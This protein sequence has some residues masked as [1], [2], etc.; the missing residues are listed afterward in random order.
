MLTRPPNRSAT[1]ALI[2][3]TCAHTAPANRF[4]PSDYYPSYNKPTSVERFLADSQGARRSAALFGAFEYLVVMDADMILRRPLP[5]P[6]AL[7]VRRGHIVGGEYAY[8]NGADNGLADR[9]L[10]PPHAPIS[11]VGG[12]I[13]AHVADLERITPLWRKYTLDV[14]TAGEEVWEE[15]LANID[16]S[17]CHV[18]F[19]TTF[20]S[21]KPEKGI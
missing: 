19:R 9:F 13:M 14:R 4:D 10:P 6:A 7:G 21:H 18:L 2:S 17:Q 15:L 16:W 8:L 5:P 12:W 11:R 3:H 20:P 1:D